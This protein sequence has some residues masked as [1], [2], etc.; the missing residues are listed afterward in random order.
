V[1]GNGANVWSTIATPEMEPQTGVRRNSTLVPFVVRRR[2]GSVFD[3]AATFMA[4]LRASH[5]R[6]ALV[7]PWLFGAALSG[8]FIFA[9]YRLANAP[10]SPGVHT[11]SGPTLALTAAS[12]SASSAAAGN[13]SAVNASLSSPS[14]ASRVATR[15]ALEPEPLGTTRA[16]VA[17][18]SDEDDADEN[19]RPSTTSAALR[20]QDLQLAPSRAER[21]L[22]SSGRAKAKGKAWSKRS[23]ARARKARRSKRNHDFEP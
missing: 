15:P 23:K 18:L 17:S 12:S 5:P 20:T 14:A 3:F 16:A 22:T 9:L 1:F 11:R 2:F 4:N 8:V 6:C 7:G 13:A 19:P 10:P 21:Q